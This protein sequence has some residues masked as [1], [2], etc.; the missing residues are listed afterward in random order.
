[1]PVHSL[2]SASPVPSI[3]SIDLDA[4]DTDADERQKVIQKIFASAELS[5][6]ARG[7]RARLAYA[8]F[9]ASRNITQAQLPD[10][11]AKTR[12]LAHANHASILNTASATLPHSQGTPRG[13]KRKAPSGAGDQYYASPS[14]QGQRGNAMAPPASSRLHNQRSPRAST[15]GVH[16]SPTASNR[17]TSGQSLFAALLGPPPLK[18]ARTVHNSSDPPVAPAARTD[19]A[20]RNSR[21]SE[22]G[23]GHGHSRRHGHGP[24]RS[25]AE[26]TRAQSRSRREEERRG[27]TRAG[28]SSKSRQTH[29]SHAHANSAT[30]A[31]AQGHHGHSRSAHA[32]LPASTSASHAHAHSPYMGAAGVRGG[33]GRGGPGETGPGGQRGDTEIER[34]AVQTLTHL[35]HARPSASVASVGSAG[36]TSPRSTL[37]AHSASGSGASEVGSMYAQSSARTGAGPPITTPTAAPA[38]LP[39]TAVAN[40]NARTTTPPRSQ[41]AHM[42]TQS[43]ASLSGGS[44]PTHLTA[45]GSQH[46]ATPR[47]DDEEAANLMLWLH[48]SPSPARPGAARARAGST[49][50]NTSGAHDKDAGAMQDRVAFR[51][52]GGGGT[53]SLKNAGRVLFADGRGERDSSAAKA[54]SRGGAGEGTTRGSL[55]REPT[56]LLP[57]SQERSSMGSIVTSVTGMSGGTSHTL[58]TAASVPAG[59]IGAG[60]SLG[61]LAPALPVP[62]EPNVIPP[63]PIEP[64]APAPGF[65]RSPPRARSSSSGAGKA[66]PGSPVRSTTSSSPRSQ[67]HGAAPPTPSASFNLSEYINVSPSPAAAAAVPSSAGSA[68]R[69]KAGSASGLRADVGRRLFEEHHHSH[70]GH[71]REGSGALGAGIDLRS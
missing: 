6:C 8:S 56:E 2:P 58:S 17:N 36:A 3:P 20:R 67:T 61:L 38:A 32:A 37:S 34:N 19:R 65:L 46:Q 40:G 47:A 51:A 5:L 16:A 23:H 53:A 44:F 25:I 24:V 18:Q 27:P 60:S 35:L 41:G 14:A 39:S 42:R 70:H 15:S 10:L 62:G 1:M 54:Q 71:A 57:S 55:K 12:P 28:K 50:S 49:A 59:G 63:T 11:E 64:S 52:L 22:H 4:M 7:L 29:S 48:T 43:S 33:T 21:A 13:A 30:H 69:V 66:E 68:S 9:K 26:G 31:H 45:P